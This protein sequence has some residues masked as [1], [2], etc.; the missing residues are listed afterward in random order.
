MAR[1]PIRWLTGGVVPVRH[2][3]CS[4][5]EKIHDAWRA[6]VMFAL[7]LLRLNLTR[8][9][10]KLD[11]LTAK[12]AHMSQALDDLT[13]QVAGTS[14]VIDSAVVLINGLADKVDALIAAGNSDP[15]LALLASDL[16]AKS[17]ALAA[18]V[19]ENPVP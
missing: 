3:W 7:D 13:T 15:A 4:R 6:G 12:E 8:I 9:E 16:K 17:D 18:A 14:G 1:W 11:A 19:A 2:R 10:A 5:P